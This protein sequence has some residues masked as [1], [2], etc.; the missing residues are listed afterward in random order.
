MVNHKKPFEKI[1]TKHKIRAL[2]KKKINCNN[3]KV[4]T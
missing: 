2:S 3:V 4:E 1:E